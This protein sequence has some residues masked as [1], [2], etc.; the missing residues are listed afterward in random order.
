M[1][2]ENKTI[3]KETDDNKWQWRHGETKHPYNGRQKHKMV[4]TLEKFGNFL[5]S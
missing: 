5:K 3:S 2:D 4:A 1:V